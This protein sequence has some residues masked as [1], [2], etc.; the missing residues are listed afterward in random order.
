MIQD[1]PQIG[2]EG[3]ESAGVD[4]DNIIDEDQNKTQNQNQ[5]HTEEAAIDFTENPDDS[6]EED[7]IQI[8]K[9][10]NDDIEEE[11]FEFNRDDILYKNSL[12]K[13]PV[14]EEIR[15]ED[16]EYPDE[17]EDESP[18]QELLLD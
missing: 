6:E 13:K 2:R 5:E 12:G 18:S 3:K 4:D 17:Q 16:Q 10:N 8:L 1:T 11:V 9:N 14:R 15:I 7:E